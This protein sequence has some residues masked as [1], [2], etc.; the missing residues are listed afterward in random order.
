VIKIE[1]IFAAGLLK[2]L[3]CLFEKECR[4]LTYHKWAA[5]TYFIRVHECKVAV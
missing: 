1:N 2:I 5:E 4:F 3:Y